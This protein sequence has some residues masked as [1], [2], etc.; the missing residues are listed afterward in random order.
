MICDFCHEREA[1]IYLEQ[2]SSDGLKKKVNI[3]MECAMK[4]GISTDPKSITSSI[5][6]LFKE[7]S[8]SNNK[9]QSALNKLC[10]VCGTKL[11]SIQKTG[12]TGCSRTRA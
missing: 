1:A 6:E 2:V 7:L 11:A 12:I 8:V 9:I 5:G 10:P 4:R 3:C